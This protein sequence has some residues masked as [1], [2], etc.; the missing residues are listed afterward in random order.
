MSRLIPLVA[1][2]ALAGCGADPDTANGDH[3]AKWTDPETGCVYLVY[4]HG[5]GNTRIGS[6]SIRFRADGTADCP[7]ADPAD[8]PPLQSP[9]NPE[10]IP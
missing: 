2:L 10:M 6:L 4:E 3:T 8:F 1:A 5:I 9:V 7:G